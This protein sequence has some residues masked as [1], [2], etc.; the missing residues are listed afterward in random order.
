MACFSL[1]AIVGIMLIEPV[2]EFLLRLQQ[3]HAIKKPTLRNQTSLFNLI[4]NTKSL[5]GS[6]SQ[7]IRRADDLVAL[8]HDQ[9]RGWFNGFVEDIMIKISRKATTVRVFSVRVIMTLS[10]SSYSL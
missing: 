9:E 4:Q 1:V 2:D 6:E 10:H 5:V 7:W 3:I 8:A